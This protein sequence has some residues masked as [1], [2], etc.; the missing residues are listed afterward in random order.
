MKNIEYLWVLVLFKIV[1]SP[2][3]R[4]FGFRYMFWVLG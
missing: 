2:N 4:V 3:F 1:I